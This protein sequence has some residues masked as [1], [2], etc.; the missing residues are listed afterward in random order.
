MPREDSAHDMLV[1]LRRRKIE[2]G[3]GDKLE[4]MGM[5]GF[6][7]IM[8]NAKRYRS[9]VS[10]GKWGQKLVVRGGEIRTRIGPLK[11]WN[12]Y[13]VTP[14]LPKESFRDRWPEMEQDIRRIAGSMDPEIAN[15]LKE[16]LQRQKL[17]KGI[18]PMTNE[19]DRDWLSRLE[20]QSRKSRSS[21]WM[22]LPR[23]WA[24]AGFAPLRSILSAVPRF[25]NEFEWPLEERLTQFTANFEA[26]GGHVVR[27]SNREEVGLFI[28][29]KAMEMSAATIL[30]QQEEA[31]DRLGLEESLPEARSFLE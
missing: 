17:G 19:T 2:A 6:S 18:K 5:K 31:L 26:A 3:R 8:G 27:L 15:R 13:R 22:E 20:E 10:L 14:S 9:V 21:S 7:A 29:D 28:R 4:A 25:W 30:R 12:S 1:S 23:S 24:E 11:G 16:R